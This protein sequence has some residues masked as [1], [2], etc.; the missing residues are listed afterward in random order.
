MSQGSRWILGNGRNI[1]FRDDWW[2]GEGLLPDSMW[3]SR[4]KVKCINL[5][6]PWV[7]DYISD[8][9]WVDLISLYASL[10]SMHSWPKMIIIPSS[11]VEDVVIWHGSTS[12]Q[13]LVVDAFRIITKSFTPPPFLARVWDKLLIPKVNIFFLVIYTKQDL[14]H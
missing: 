10:S 7:V 3:A 2:I 1:R 13:F 6:G 9:I 5:I 4:F 11:L 8:G 12:G 14:Y